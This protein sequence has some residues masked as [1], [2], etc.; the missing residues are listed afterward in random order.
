MVG[1]AQEESEFDWHSAMQVKKDRKKKKNTFEVIDYVRDLAASSMTGQWDPK[2]KWHDVHGDKKSTTGG[3][4]TLATMHEGGKGKG[5]TGGKYKVKIM[6]HGSSIKEL[7]YEQEEEPSF[8]LIVAD[9]KAA[10][11]V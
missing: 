7:E 1:I 8:D 10:F 11:G 9:F 2:G 6:E 4:F 3:K 5:S